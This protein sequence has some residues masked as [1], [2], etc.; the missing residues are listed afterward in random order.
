[1][2][3]K[4]N[5]IIS[6]IDGLE[7]LFIFPSCG[8]ES[9]SLGTSWIEYSELLKNKEESKQKKELKPIFSLNNLYLGGLCYEG[10]IEKIISKHIN[11]EGNI[12]INKSDNI[13]RD[14]A[15]IIMNNHIIA[16]CSGKME[17]GARALGNRSIL[18]NP[19]DWSNV[20]KIN[21]K[22]K[23]RDFW[24][25]FAPSLLKEKASK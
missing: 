20:E 22:I 8:D 23:K 5:K 15:E 13:S 18:A 25:P 6:E 14:T 3:V 7:E 11:E 9:L 19:K 12:S 24:M 17:W 1:M 4:A 21:S 16:R 10:N 2:N